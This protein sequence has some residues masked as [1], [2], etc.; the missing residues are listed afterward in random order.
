[1]FV[2]FKGPL[3]LQQHIKD[4]P[5]LA[6]EPKSGAVSHI[7]L[8]LEFDLNWE[9]IP[10]IDGVLVTGLMSCDQGVLHRQRGCLPGS[11]NRP[12]FDDRIRAVEWRGKEGGVRDKSE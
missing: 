5:I 1:M 10:R 12:L 2:L 6:D 3:S 9:R 4:I 7:R 8:W 11:F